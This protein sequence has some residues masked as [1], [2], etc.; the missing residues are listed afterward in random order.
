MVD[1]RRDAIEGHVKR[2]RRANVF[3]H[4]LVIAFAAVEA[5]VERVDDDGGGND[6]RG[7]RADVC[8]QS[9]ML[10]DEIDRDIDKPEWHRAMVFGHMVQ[11]PSCDPFAETVSTFNCAINNRSLLNFVTAIFP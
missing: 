1:N 5:A 7:L 6:A 11:P 2:V 8:D 10:L 9:V 4:V 3:S